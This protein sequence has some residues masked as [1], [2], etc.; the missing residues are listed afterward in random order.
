M[1]NKFGILMS[2][3][4]YFEIKNLSL[5]NI[6]EI[7]TPLTVEKQKD[8]RIYYS[9]YFTS[10]LSAIDILLDKKQNDKHAEFKNRFDSEFIFDDFPN[11]EHNFGYIKQ[12]RNSIIHRGIDITS[13]AHFKDSF[14]LIIAQTVSNE[15]GRMQYTPFDYYLIDIIKRCE[16]S[17]PNIIYNYLLDFDFF[18]I[19][20]DQ[21][22]LILKSIESIDS[23]D[24]MPDWV[25]KLARKEIPNLDF[26]SMHNVSIQ[27]CINIIKT[28]LLGVKDSL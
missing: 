12:L 28:D 24:I 23:S 1:K 2:V 9:Q 14:P 17:I 7:K 3:Q 26:D 6:L 22:T 20:N 5:K 27:N 18:K 13:S 19:E 11:I 15:S 16:R 21:N 25:K 10:L 8:L 4:W